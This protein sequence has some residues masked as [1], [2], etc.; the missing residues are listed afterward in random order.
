MKPT[1]DH[2]GI[3]VK[4][5]DAAKIYKDMGLEVEHVENFESQRVKTAFL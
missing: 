2:I 5:L 4:S 3:A 1:L